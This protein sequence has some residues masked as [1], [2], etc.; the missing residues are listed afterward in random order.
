MSE[1]LE[2]ALYN[3]AEK[4]TSIAPTMR[5]HLKYFGWSVSQ[6]GPSVFYNTKYP[7]AYRKSKHI[8][9][10]FLLTTIV[11]TYMFTRKSKHNLEK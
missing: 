3:A 11:L 7:Q 6:Y 8:H 10:P 2:K 1:G 9:A 4:V 5:T